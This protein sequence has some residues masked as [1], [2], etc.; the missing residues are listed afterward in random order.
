MPPH[1]PQHSLESAW[2]PCSSRSSGPSSSSC[3]SRDRFR[4]RDTFSRV[5]RRRWASSSPCGDEKLRPERAARASAFLRRSS[6]SEL[7]TMLTWAQGR[8]GVSVGSRALCWGGF[9]PIRGHARS[10][11][12]QGAM[13]RRPCCPPSALTDGKAMTPHSFQPGCK[14]LRATGLHLPLPSSA[15]QQKTQSRDVWSLGYR[16]SRQDSSNRKPYCWRVG[17]DETGFKAAPALKGVRDHHW[18]PGGPDLGQDPAKSCLG[19]RGCGSESVHG[20]CQGC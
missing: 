1:R 19:P 15:R 7:S 17:R 10:G 2:L 13:W 3:P 20:G 16:A 18:A 11:S 9:Q 14:G 6:S 4:F 8:R 12:C 5:R